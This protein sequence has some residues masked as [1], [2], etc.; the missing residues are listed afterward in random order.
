MPHDSTFIQTSSP[1]SHWGRG[2]CQSDLGTLKIQS[3]SLAMRISL[4]C[5]QVQSFQAELTR[6]QG[7]QAGKAGVRSHSPSEWSAAQKWELTAAAFLEDLLAFCCAGPRQQC[8]A[9]TEMSYCCLWALPTFTAV[10]SWDV[11]QLRVNE[12]CKSRVL[13]LLIK[14]LLTLQISLPFKNL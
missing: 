2:H 3:S 11:L 5:W 9:A 13:C 6:T 1:L 4:H 10:G 14:Q 7:W 8:W 12:T